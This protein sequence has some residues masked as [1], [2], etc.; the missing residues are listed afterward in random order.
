MICKKG[1]CAFVLSP[2]FDILQELLL[3]CYK[4]LFLGQ[5]RL[6]LGHSLLRCVQLLTLQQQILF[7]PLHLLHRGHL[8]HLHL[9]R[10][11]EL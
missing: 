2:S 6:Q 4:V 9:L 10:N 7:Q 8:H 1:P 3:L 11:T 5:L